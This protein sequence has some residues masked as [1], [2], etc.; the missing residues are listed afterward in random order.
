MEFIGMKDGSFNCLIK[1]GSGLNASIGFIK[2]D[3][4]RF[5]FKP[6]GLPLNTSQTLAVGNELARLNNLRFKGI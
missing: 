4:A 6:A 1:L 5:V 2:D 3:L